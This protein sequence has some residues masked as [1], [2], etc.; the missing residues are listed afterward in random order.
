M[1]ISVRSITHVELTVSDLD[2]SLR[3]YRDG[4][5]LREAHAPLEF[6]ASGVAD[7]DD[8]EAI[9]EI[10]GRNLRVAILR[11]GDAPTGPFRLGY[12]PSGI[13][14]VQP[15]A[16][17]PSGKAIK[18]DQIGITHIA[19]RVDGPL[20]DVESRLAD[21]DIAIKGR[22]NIGTDDFPSRSLFIEDP[23]GI[24]I[25]LDIVP[26]MASSG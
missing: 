3:F 15:K 25:Q 14:L 22:Q 2:R 10:P 9:Y 5:G 18:A 26:K 24:L 17:P 20:E 11:Y 8:V 21:F 13:V 4:L 23:D 6:A 16:P 1:P 19:F 7:G 12:E